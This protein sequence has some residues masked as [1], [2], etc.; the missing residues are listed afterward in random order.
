MSSSEPCLGRV[1]DGRCRRRRRCDSFSVGAVS[2]GEGALD[3]RALSRRPVEAHA[4]LGRVHRLRDAEAEVQDM[5]RRKASVASQSIAGTEARLLRRERVGHD[6]HRRDGRAVEAGAARLGAASGDGLQRIGERRRPVSSGRVD[7]ERGHRIM[8]RQDQTRPRTWSAPFSATM[9]VGALVLLLGRSGMT[10]E[11]M[12][13]RPS[14]P[15]TFSAGS[16]TAMSSLPILQV[17]TG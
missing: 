8:C 16:T 17:P 9:R 11:S 12:T 10:D 6:V 13:R 3:Q 2:L 4:A 7:R 1:D 5:C 14:R 15:R